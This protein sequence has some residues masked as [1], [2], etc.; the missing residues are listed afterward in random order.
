MRSKRGEQQ[1]Y[2]QRTISYECHQKKPERMQDYE[3]MQQVRFRLYLD[4]IWDGALC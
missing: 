4:V 1:V 2:R 3:I